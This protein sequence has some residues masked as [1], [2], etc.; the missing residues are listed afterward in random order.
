MWFVP[1]KTLASFY[2]SHVKSS[3]VCRMCFFYFVECEVSIV[4]QGWFRDSSWLGTLWWCTTNL[5]LGSW[6]M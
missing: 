5:D 6:G 1:V 2:N 4:S 3:F